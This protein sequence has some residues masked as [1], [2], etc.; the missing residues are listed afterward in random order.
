MSL[1]N[2]KIAFWGTPDLTLEYLNSFERA[3][4]LPIAIITNP[5]R[6]KGRGHELSSP[7]PKIWATERNIPVLQPEKLNDDF[8]EVLKN[9]DLDISIVVAYGKIIPERFINLPK[10]GTLNVHYSILPHLRGASPV[11]SAILIGD[12]ETGISIQK[13][14]FKLDSGPIIAE[15]TMTIDS[16]ETAPA[17]RARLTAR[18]QELLLITLPDYLDGKVTPKPQDETKAT[19]CGKSKKEDG[20]IDPNGNA[21][22]NYN[23]FRAHFE[24]PRTYFFINE[25]RVIITKAKFENNQFVIEKVLPEGKKEI[26]YS[27]FLRNQNLNK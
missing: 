7:A 26:A 21:I 19:H 18:A 9:L 10:S 25:K 11:E 13:M 3:G 2:K 24:W 6:P 14:A 5:D 27:D 16:N 20:L 12:T 4:F 23:K 15:E 22:L 1:K 8:F 17:L